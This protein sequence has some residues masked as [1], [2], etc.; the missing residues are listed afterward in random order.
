[1]DLSLVPPLLEHAMIELGRFG[2][3]KR[4]SREALDGVLLDEQAPGRGE[5]CLAMAGVGS[6]MAYERLL[7]ALE[8]RDGWVR[9]MAYRALRHASGDDHFCDWLYAPADARMAAVDGY[10]LWLD[11]YADK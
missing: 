10:K 11:G 7:G 4:S 9:F 3:R 2:G 6:V 5:A 8:D 1:M